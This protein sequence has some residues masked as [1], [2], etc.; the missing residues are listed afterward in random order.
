MAKG[1]V[2]HFNNPVTGN[3]HASVLGYALTHTGVDQSVVEDIF[4][5]QLYYKASPEGNSWGSLAG[6]NDSSPYREPNIRAYAGLVNL[7]LSEKAL[8][9]IETT[10]QFFDY[11]NTTIDTPIGISELTSYVNKINEDINLGKNVI[12]LDIV[13]L[14]TSVPIRERQYKVYPV[15][16]NYTNGVKMNQT[17]NLEVF[18]FNLEEGKQTSLGHLSNYINLA[19][20]NAYDVI[21]NII[22]DPEASVSQKETLKR[23]LPLI[24]MLP[25]IK[26]EFRALG[27]SKVEGDRLFYIGGQYNVK[28]NSLLFSIDTLAGLD[29][30]AFRNL[31][32]HELTHGITLA[33]F[34][35][36]VSEADKKL[37]SRITPIFN[38]Y[39]DK[40]KGEKL[41]G[42][43]YGLTDPSEFLSEF[44]ANPEFRALLQEEAPAEVTSIWKAIWNFIL[45]KLGF[46]KEGKLRS[47]IENIDTIL[48]EY[49]N[50]VLTNNSINTSLIGQNVPFSYT[51]NYVLTPEQIAEADY[52]FDNS[53]DFL[54]RVEALLNHPSLIDWYKIMQ[55]ANNVN[56]NMSML[57]NSEKEFREIGIEDAKKSFKSLVGFLHE[58]AKYLRGVSL[59]LDNLKEDKNIPV[60]DLFRKAYHAKELGE[61]YTNFVDLYEQIMGNV[62]KKTVLNTQLKNIRALSNALTTDY[63]NIASVAIAKKLAKE[64][65]PQT[66]GLREGIQNNIKKFEEEKAKA[67]SQNNDRLVKA[68]DE[69]IKLEKSQLNKLASEAN[70]VQALT[71]H[72]KDINVFTLYL[73]SAN[74]SNNILTGTIGGM[75][76]NMFDD[77]NAEGMVLE[78]RMKK[79][80]D[81]LQGHLRSKGIGLTTSL[82][83]EEAFGRFLRKVKVLEVRRGNLEE[84]EALVFNTE[85]DE[86][87]FINDLTRLRH[88]ITTLEAKKSLTPEEKN[89]LVRKNKELD[90]LE[91]DYLER[92]YT[93]AYYDIH[94]LLSEEARDA[95]KSILDEMHKIQG[96][97]ISEDNTEEDLLR[98]EELKFQL[99]RLESDYDEYGNKKSEEGLRIAQNIREWKTAKSAAELYVYEITP[100][101]RA[102]FTSTYTAKKAEVDK[103]KEAYD[104]AIANQMSEE[105]IAIKKTAYDLKVKDFNLWKKNNT[106][107][108][109]SQEFYKERREILDNISSIQSRINIPGIPTV[110]AMYEEMFNLLKGFKDND[111]FYMGEKITDEESAMSL[112]VK[113]LE[114]KIDEVK[115]LYSENTSLTSAEQNLLKG[116]FAQLDEMQTRVGTP[117]YNRVYGNKFAEVKSNLIKTNPD[118]YSD[119]SDESLLNMETAKALQ[120]TKWYQDN[121]KKTK[122]YN[123]NTKKWEDSY[124][125]LFY[126]TYTRPTNED[127]VLENEPSFRWNTIKINDKVDPKTGKPVFINTEVQRYGSSK[128]VTLRKDQ[129][130]YK[131]SNFNLDSTEK[132][133]LEEVLTIYAELEKGLP[134]NLKKGL[135]LPSV[136]KSGLEV[137]PSSRIGT[138]GSLI[139]NNAKTMWDSVL[140]KDDLSGPREEVAGEGSMLSKVN[141][142]LFLRYNSPLEA[143]RVSMNFLNT[144]TQ[145]GADVIRFKK[146]YAQV[147][148]LFGMQ[149]V[150]AKNVPGSNAEKMIANLFEYHLKGQS[151][152]YLSSNPKLRAAENLLGGALNLSATLGIAFRLP[153]IIKNFGAGTTTL[154]TQLKAFGLEKEDV[155]KAMVKNAKFMPALFKSYLESGQDTPYI[156][157]LK[158]FNAMPGN[159]ILQTGK[160]VSVTK[161]EKAA[162]S[163]NPLYWLTFSRDFGEFQMRSAAMEALSQKYR[164]TLQNGDQV[165]MLDAYVTDA[166]GNLKV[167]DDIQSIED[168]RKLENR[169]RGQLNTINYLV[170]GAYGAMDKAEYQRYS[171]GRLVGFMKSWLPPQFLRRFSGRRIDYR[172]GIEHEGIHRGMVKYLKHLMQQRFNINSAW[173]LM[174]ERERAEAIS[175]TYD[176]IVLAGLMG[177]IAI[178]N[179]LRYQDDDEESNWVLYALLYNLLLIED[180][181]ST[182]NPI[183]GPLAIYNA[184]VKNNVNG[185][186]IAEYYLSRNFVMPFSSVMDIM[187]L[188]DAYTLG[189]GTDVDLDMFGEYVPLSRNGKALN[190]KRYPPDPLLKGQFDIVSRLEKLMGIDVSI[191]AVMNPEYIFRKYE[192][193]NERY[194]IS[195]LD[196][197]IKDSKKTIRSIDKQLKAM[198]RQLSYLE[199]P[200]TISDMENTMSDLRAEK[201][202]A[203]MRTAELNRENLESKE[204]LID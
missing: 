116:Y 66:Q 102:L 51:A 74:H 25:P 160:N 91:E 104:N 200:E 73:E 13:P 21:A 172:A 4:Q 161:L 125:P 165:P 32:I 19:S 118:R 153:S 52:L 53:S 133:I 152:K 92:P 85:M 7:N 112:R 18:N 186:G 95:R 24:N 158:Y 64:F 59:S 185:Q 58:T 154:F 107:F 40:Y 48:N 76:A 23:M 195:T 162:K 1:C 5:N 78:R 46:V 156:A 17:F 49:F 191:N 86:I 128:R 80:G 142:K 89:T 155:S 100:Q 98:L 196:A 131:N 35:N 93:Q 193:R 20:P 201:D 184:R 123:Q 138:I 56:I 65:E 3:R 124:Q 159:N 145:Y 55:E 147:P 150:L 111:G 83:Y 144:V 71:G 43:Y 132:Q 105:D 181:L 174:S 119:Q 135:E 179:S 204:S 203:L 101:N 8:R 171:L 166:D 28:E 81:K 77:A 36:P 87:A 108:K 197:D 137:S 139:T 50:D 148:Y 62:G 167:R 57:Y 14:D 114:A 94:N 31:M 151:K 192:S 175:G 170:Q 122:K 45:N 120:K 198:E 188:A 146:V 2:I 33:S 12:A 130:K 136:P 44:L 22:S 96:H 84:R 121:H 134:R 129:T 126:W 30:N 67:Q 70:L 127:Y 41:E 79:L 37:V 164:I 157:K 199:D 26:M 202:E 180:E 149:D 10:Q 169:F 176:F 106:V 34:I 42:V 75:I 115:E 187:K 182:L 113:E 178:L 38:K 117:Y 143:D 168:L 163:F 16:A 63:F 140:G 69:R 99:E 11:F 110:S 27:V 60:E 177:V 9:Y 29:T 173:R 90:S 54:T 183:A 109:I 82:S 6:T 39:Q 103:A 141:R 61:Q 190:P 88:E 194:Y 47:D 189:L 97:G 72:V 15:L 68:L